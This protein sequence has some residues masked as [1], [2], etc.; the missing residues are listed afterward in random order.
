[1]E[2][3]EEHTVAHE[4]HLELLAETSLTLFAATTNQL[5]C[6]VD[7]AVLVCEVLK[8]V[9]AK[10]AIASV[11]AGDM[12]QDSERLVVS[13][14]VDE[15]FGRLFET[16][17]DCSEKKDAEG[18]GSDGEHQVAPAHVARLGTAWLTWCDSITGQ[19]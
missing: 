11:V 17:H 4:F 2:I 10:S 6:A 1:L 16:E 3:A 12:L 5:G 18:D 7:A 9:V 15:E 13:T 14:T 8:R 19:Q